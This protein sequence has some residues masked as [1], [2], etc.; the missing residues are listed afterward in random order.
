MFVE[1][2]L[3]EAEKDVRKV[4]LKR[5]STFLTRVHQAKH[6]SLTFD[7]GM[8]HFQNGECPEFAHSSLETHDLHSLL[9][10]LLP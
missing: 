10:V 7:F 4:R 9:I 8:A 5:V 3:K 1:C 2:W 6:P